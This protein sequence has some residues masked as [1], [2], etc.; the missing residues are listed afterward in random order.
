MSSSCGAGRHNRLPQPSTIHWHGLPVPP[1]QDGNPSK[2][3]AP[4]AQHVYRFTLPQGSAG[5]YWYH[6]HP[7]MMSAGLV[8]RGLAGPIIVRACQRRMPGSA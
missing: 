6:P 7:H 1:D 3:V 4:G 2:P 8:Y 5:T